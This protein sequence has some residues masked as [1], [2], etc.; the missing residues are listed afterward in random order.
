MQ[1]PPLPDPRRG[2]FATMLVVDGAPRELDAHLARLGRSAAQLYG[3]ALPER[4]ARALV[5]QRAA[6]CALARL[7]LTFVPGAA[8]APPALEAVAREIDRRIVLPG[9]DGALTLATRPVAGWRGGHKWADRALLERLEADAAPH[10]A[11]LVDAATGAVLETTRAN[12]FC[13]DGDGTL[14][15][16]PLD[17]TIL[18]GVTRALVIA[19]ARAAGRT[20]REAPLRPADL[21]AGAEVFAT[22]AVRGIEPVGA[23][24][25]V[26]LGGAG[27][28]AAELADALARRW[29]AV[30]GA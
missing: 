4:R 16:P 7:R 22:G 24:D 15:T 29:L 1:L 8:G 10:G 17:G 30:D 28:V 18:P 19:L 26:A 6:G 27:P 3:V 20:V 11:L 9:P 5:A 23:L 21:H 12:V 13:V 25:G 2:V 14:R